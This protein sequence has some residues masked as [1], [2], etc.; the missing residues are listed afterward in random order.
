[1]RAQRKKSGGMGSRLVGVPRDR[2]PATTISDA[3]RATGRGRQPLPR[4]SATKV[5]PFSFDHLISAGE[6][7]ATARV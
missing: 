4:A 2:K 5:A 7:R 6:E 3:E 1:M